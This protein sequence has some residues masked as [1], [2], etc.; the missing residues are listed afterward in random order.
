MRFDLSLFSATATVLAR[1]S[2]RGQ[3][4]RI[5]DKRR[6]LRTPELEFVT[7]EERGRRIG[8]PGIQTDEPIPFERGSRGRSNIA[9]RD[10]KL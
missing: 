1:K 3:S 4:T 6:M 8:E 2:K 7:S 10:P 5:L 9:D